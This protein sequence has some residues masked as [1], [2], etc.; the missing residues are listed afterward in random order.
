MTAE[1]RMRDIT[2]TK[3]LFAEDN[4]D[5]FVILQAFL[6]D[7]G[8]KKVTG[9]TNGKE[10][11]ELYETMTDECG[12]IILDIQMPIMNGVEALEHIRSRNKSIPVIALTAFALKEDVR[13]FMNAG[14]TAYL[15]KPYKQND[16][17]DIIEKCLEDAE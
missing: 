11:I 14:F 6:K 2:Q 3:I 9:T 1:E 5:N 12:L 10:L 15:A 8:F 17:Y 16:L 4:P 7:M 13:R